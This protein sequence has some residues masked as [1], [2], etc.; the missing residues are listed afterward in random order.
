MVVLPE[1]AARVRGR[2]KDVA[3][4]V[5]LFGAISLQQRATPLVVDGFAH[6]RAICQTFATRR[7]GTRLCDRLVVSG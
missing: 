7:L 6:N 4:L 1:T 2:K 5:M 3:P